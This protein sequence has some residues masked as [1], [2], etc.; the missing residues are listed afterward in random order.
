MTFTLTVKDAIKS[1]HDLRARTGF[2]GRGVPSGTSMR[3]YSFTEGNQRITDFNL[4]TGFDP[5]VWLDQH[6]ARRFICSPH[7]TSFQEN[8]AWKKPTPIKDENHLCVFLRIVWHH[9]LQ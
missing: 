7:H 2:G 3:T 4:S 8:R 1:I 9:I 6:C 5:K